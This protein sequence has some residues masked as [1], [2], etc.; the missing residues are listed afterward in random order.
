MGKLKIW[1]R[2]HKRGIAMAIAG[3]LALIMLLGMLSP[4]LFSIGQ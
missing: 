4:L 2:N 1:L 3:L